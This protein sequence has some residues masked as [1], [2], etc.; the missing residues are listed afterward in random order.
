[1]D[2][3]R[4]GEQS[5]GT[6]TRVVALMVP[7]RCAGCRFAGIALVH[8]KDGTRSRMIHCKRL[9]CDNW[10]LPDKEGD[11]LAVGYVHQMAAMAVNRSIVDQIDRDPGGSK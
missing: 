1:M 11:R 3:L 10:V 8:L 7:G 9:D 6:T 2:E 4:E 5:E